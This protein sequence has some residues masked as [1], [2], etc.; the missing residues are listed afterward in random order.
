[1]VFSQELQQQIHQN[2]QEALPFFGKKKD[3]IQQAVAQC[4]EPQRLFMEFLY[5]AMP[6]SDVANYSFETFY[7]YADHA[8]FLLEKMPWCQEI[9]PEIFLNEVLLDRKSVV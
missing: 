1:M 7:S 2:Y 3:E 9:P 4:P 5:S 6:L 8:A